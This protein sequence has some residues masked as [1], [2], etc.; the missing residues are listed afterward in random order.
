MSP[1]PG[2]IV[3]FVDFISCLIGGHV[4]LSQYDTLHFSS[5]MVEKYEPSFVHRIA[6]WRNFDD[7][8]YFGSGK[9]K[10]SF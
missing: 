8:A 7:L 1:Q 9:H 5:I 10:R 2:G 6:L 3:D 4:S